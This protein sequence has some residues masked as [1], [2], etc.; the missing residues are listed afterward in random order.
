MSRAGSRSRQQQ[1]LVE[2]GPSISEQ[3]MSSIPAILNGFFQERRLEMEER[4]LQQQ[5][6]MEERRLQQEQ[7]IALRREQMNLRIAEMTARREEDR[8]RYEQSLAFQLGD[9]DDRKKD[10]RK[11]D[12]S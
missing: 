5:Q 11:T 3:I 4:R 9:K 2:T 6:A 1:S 7:E 8:I 12:R 10:N